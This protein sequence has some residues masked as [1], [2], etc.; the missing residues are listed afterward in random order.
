[1]ILNYS[2][3]VSEDKRYYIEYY[4]TDYYKLVVSK[5]IIGLKLKVL[6]FS[7]YLRI[8]QRL[9]IIKEINILKK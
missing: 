2:I 8:K 5:T 3:Y 9:N 7:K 1:M 4:N 6:L